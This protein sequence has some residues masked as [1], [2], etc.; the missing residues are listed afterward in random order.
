[1]RSHG[2]KLVFIALGVVAASVASYLKWQNTLMSL[3][4]HP[5]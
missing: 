4:E 3:E 1:V 5:Y 2:G